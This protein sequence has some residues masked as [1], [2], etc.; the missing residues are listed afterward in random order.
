MKVKTVDV[1]DV[2]D[3][4][5]RSWHLAETTMFLSEMLC[6]G[7]SASENEPVELTGDQVTAIGHAFKVVSMCAEIIADELGDL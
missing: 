6:K 1:E 5:A 7:T 3:V 2:E 4:W